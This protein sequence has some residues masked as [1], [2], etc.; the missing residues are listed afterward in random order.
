[1]PEIT[2]APATDFAQSI[3]MGEGGQG[4]S[5]LYVV[6]VFLRV[7]VGVIVKVGVTVVV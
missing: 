2:G 6:R 3:C 1:M 5:K 4:L 7:L